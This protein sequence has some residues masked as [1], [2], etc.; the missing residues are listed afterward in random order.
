MP[1]QTQPQRIRD[2]LDVLAD[3]GVLRD[4]PEHLRRYCA[5][6]DC[7]APPIEGSNYCTGHNT[8]PSGEAA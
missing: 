4:L 8:P 6:P 1:E 7:E 2:A 5:V 3:E